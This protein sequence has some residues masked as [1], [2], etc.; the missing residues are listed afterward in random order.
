MEAPKTLAEHF[1]LVDDFFKKTFRDNN[2]L[3]VGLKTVQYA[4]TA[5]GSDTL[6]PEVLSNEKGSSEPMVLQASTKPVAVVRL[7]PSKGEASSLVSRTPNFFLLSPRMFFTQEGNV[8]GKVKLLCGVAVPKLGLLEQGVQFWS[9]GLISGQVKVCDVI[10]GLNVKGRVAVNTIASAAGDASSINL[11]YQRPELYSG[12]NVQ[13]NGLGSTNVAFDIGSKFLNLL[14]GAGFERQSLSEVDIASGAEQ[15]N[16]MYIGGGFTGWNWSMGA[17]FTHFNGVWGN[18]R[19]AVLQKLRPSTTVACAYD[20]DTTNSQAKVSI[21]FSQ[22][23][24]LRLPCFLR[25][26]LFS[27]RSPSSAN[28]SQNVS[29]AYPHTSSLPIVFAA[30]AESNGNASATIRSM[31]N[32][33]IRCGVVAHRNFRHPSNKTRFGLVVSVEQDSS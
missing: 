32:N 22:G 13:R 6:P 29:T 15:I 12:L 11:F 14:V 27:S 28:N 3:F 7:S 10:D 19:I 9:D 21:G 18:G 20:L 33:S 23:M 5:L 31:F 17:K 1:L 24:L 25:S 8:L 30:K 4:E 16:A 26:S 2:T